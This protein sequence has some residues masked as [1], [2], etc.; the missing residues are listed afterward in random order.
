MIRLL[1]GDCREVLPT[2]SANSVHC[3][4]TSPP[5]WGLRDYGTGQWDGGDPAC[6][7]GAAYRAHRNAGRQTGVNGGV[8]GSERDPVRTVCRCG[9]R[10]IDRQ[11]GLEATPEEYIATM[12][13]V[14]REVRRVMRPDAT[15]WVNLGDGFRDK[16]LLMMPARLALA[17]QADGWWLRSDIIW[18]KRNPMPE[19][20]TDR[21]TIAHEHVFLLAKSPRYFFDAE[22]VREESS[23]NTHAGYASN[24][25]KTL[26]NANA[27][28]VKPSCFDGYRLPTRNMRNVWEIATSPFADAHFATFP[29]A[30]VERCIRA[31]TSERGCCAACGAPWARV[32]ERSVAFTSG[33]G[34][35]GNVPNGKYA[36]TAQALSGD[37]DIRMGPSVATTTTGW[38]PSCSPCGDARPP[39][40]ATVLDPFSGAGTTLLVADRLQRDAIG[41]ELNSVYTAMAKKRIVYDAPLFAEVAD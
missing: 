35:A 29:P 38:S 16:Q 10:R 25:A 41:I 22:A 27:F 36:G 30:L 3:V 12:V 2:L 23:E 9:A 14:F 5:Y 15:C 11:I 37:Y 19:S 18:A 17:L 39:V 34:R 13:A 6:D 32:V 26:A 7:H 8:P 1:E 40:P 31:G 24:G 21:P 4:V 20:A 33:S 28:G